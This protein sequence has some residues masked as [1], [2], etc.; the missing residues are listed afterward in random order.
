[1]L[2][3]T[4]IKNDFEAMLRVL[5][6]IDSV[7]VRNISQAV[8]CMDAYGQDIVSYAFILNFWQ[9]TPPDNT[10]PALSNM[11]ISLEMKVKENLKNEEEPIASDY[12]MQLCI[13]G[14]KDGQKYMCSWHLDLDNS[15]DHRYIHP[16]FHLTYGGKIMRDMF[17]DGHSSGFGQLLLLV[18]PRIPC[19]PMD[20]ILA[21]DF[22]LNHFYKS[23]DIGEILSNSQ[24]RKAVKAS[25]RRLWKPYYDSLY[26]FFAKNEKNGLGV[27][28]M[29]GLIID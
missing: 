14:V 17:H 9:I 24:Y 11:D 28:Y 6:R 2:N 4:I 20:G 8:G 16:R 23:D 27:K 1:M 18:T 25:Q 5:E 10:L 3:A 15:T 13:S 21:I 12:A 22:I 26:R 7:D 29:P 19:M